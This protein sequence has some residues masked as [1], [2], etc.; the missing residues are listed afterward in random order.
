MVTLAEKNFTYIYRS[1]IL[2][3][4]PHPPGNTQISVQYRTCIYLRSLDVVRSCN[5]KFTA[6]WSTL[7]GHVVGDGSW[8][9]SH[10]HR[11]ISRLVGWLF[12]YI[13]PV[14]RSPPSSSTAGHPSFTR[15]NTAAGPPSFD[16]LSIHPLRLLREWLWH[17]YRC[18]YNWIMTRHR[19]F[20]YMKL[21]ISR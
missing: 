10:R 21:E 20:G 11:A 15:R 13:T 19:M 6:G 17:R 18:C 16:H 14:G 9:A 7:T 1:R 2:P 12:R 3:P 4:P 8:W 5:W